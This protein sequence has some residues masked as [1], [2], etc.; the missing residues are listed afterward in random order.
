[1][2]RIQW[3]RQYVK[4]AAVLLVLLAAVIYVATHS[5][6]QNQTWSNG[7]RDI[8]S[9]PADL[10]PAVSTEGDLPN[11]ADFELVA[12]TSALQ[13]Y[14]DKNTGHFKVQDKRSGDILHSYPHPEH[15]SEE[16]IGGAW[17][18][19][20]RSPLMLETVDLTLTA[21]KPEVKVS[22]LLSQNGGMTSWEKIDGGFSASF[23]LPSTQ[24]IIP[25]EVRIKDDYVETK[26]VD[27]GI[28]EGK[29]S[30]LSL[31]LFPFMGAVQPRGEEEYVMLPDGSGALYRI[32]ENLTGDRSIYREPIYGSDIAFN[33]EFTNRKAVSMP[34]YGIKSAGGTF[35]AVGTEGEAFGYLYAAPSGVYS[36]YAW[37]TLEHNYRLQYFQPTSQ[38]QAKGF[39]TYSKIR[40]GSDRAVRYYMLTEE[41]ADYPGMAA[42]YRDYLMAEHG[43]KPALSQDAAQ[44]P[45]YIDLIGGDAEKGVLTDRYLVGTTTEEAKTIV[46]RLHEL[47]IPR[48]VITYKG[49]QTGGASVAG[50]GTTVDRRL[51]G[52]EGMK[53]F[54]QYAQS[55]GDTVLLEMNYIL[56]NDGKSFRKAR[57]GVQDQAGSVLQFYSYM[58]D[59]RIT[60]VSPLYTLEKLKASLS[61]FASI[62]A[63]GLQ[64]EGTGQQLFSDY[65]PRLFA[66][67]KRGADIQSEMLMTI[68]EEL[69]QAAIIQGNAYALGHADAIRALPHDYS[70]DLFMDEAVPF[71]P[72]V[73]HGLTPYTLQWGNTRDEYRKDLLRAIEYGALPAFV[74][75]N[76]KTEEM[77]R[78][79][80]IWQYSLSFEDWHG[81]ITEE[82]Q[83]FQEALGDVQGEFITGHRTIS[84]NVKETTYA[85]GKRIIVNYNTSPVSVEGRSIAA[86]DYIVVEGGGQS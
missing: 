19:H 86:Q 15:W 4:W 69:G 77:K 28:R 35:L 43:L 31:K 48:L 12:E 60:L 83:R 49:W 25:I 67:R 16:T 3:R 44:F 55:K 63:D 52:I 62:G 80:S 61:K 74:V 11:P 39:L 5:A 30:L 2:I 37:S 45:L 71:A 27:G 51:G 66:D 50:F 1:M 21:S 34:V 75:M 8:V 78:A 58:T 24:M 79:H 47:G 84:P 13:L 76:A 70:Y 56:N 33:T 65:N 10:K 59:S 29:D 42:K 54:T 9:I 40:F 18:Q 22:S 81:T 23:A 32:K 20:L 26:V 73:L 64:L 17:R 36:R 7:E 46:D 41:N 53:S 68:K 82:Y 6:D 85:G 38:D 57:Q 14:A 72:M